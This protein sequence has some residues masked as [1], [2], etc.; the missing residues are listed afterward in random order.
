MGCIDT[1]GGTKCHCCP[2]KNSYQVNKLLEGWHGVKLQYCCKQGQKIPV[3]VLQ[4]VICGTFNNKPI[5]GRAQPGQEPHNPKSRSTKPLLQ[6]PEFQGRAVSS[7]ASPTQLGV[8]QCCCWIS[9][10]PGHHQPLF[11]PLD[12]PELLLPL[13][14]QH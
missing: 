12:S 6:D 2:Q 8:G 9:P 3:T 1:E 13:C 14:C 4:G 7:G 10:F 11:Q 5:L